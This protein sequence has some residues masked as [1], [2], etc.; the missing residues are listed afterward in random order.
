MPKKVSQKQRQKQTVIVN[1]G[2]TKQKSRTKRKSTAKRGKSNVSILPPPVHQVYT[3]PIHN[4]IPQYFSQGNQLS[5]PTLGEQQVSS[6]IKNNTK[7]EMDMSL[8]ERMQK[9]ID[10]NKNT[11]DEINSYMD[12][13]QPSGYSLD[14][15]SEIS[16][17]YSNPESDWYSRNSISQKPN[18]SLSKEMS[19]NTPR[20][21]NEE[22]LQQYYGNKNVNSKNNSMDKDLLQ[23]MEQ[24]IKDESSGSFYGP[25]VPI[26]PREQEDYF[27]RMNNIDLASMYSDK[28][29]SYDLGSMYSD[30]SAKSKSL[31]NSQ[32]KYNEMV[33]WLDRELA[34]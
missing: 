19:Q 31:G 10:A 11:M 8:I 14:D 21:S 18:Y 22:F 1:V 15:I 27:N 30:A 17:I 5:I 32:K 13:S 9:Q 23:R 20:E 12:K 33:S 24:Q 34:K 6:Q 2:T 4:L 3:S 28:S 16:S 29:G 26:N 7:N 25:R